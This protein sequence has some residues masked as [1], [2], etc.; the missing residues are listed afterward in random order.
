MT[1]CS[2]F[3]W[4]SWGISQTFNLWNVKVKS[5]SHVQL[6]VTPWTEEPTNFP[7]KSTGVGCHFL[8]QGIFPTQGS[9]PGLP[10]SRQTLYHLSHKGSPF[11]LWVDLNFLSFLSHLTSL[12]FYFRSGRF[13][14]FYLNS[15]T[16]TLL[17]EKGKHNF[18]ISLLFF[19]YSFCILYI[20]RVQYLLYF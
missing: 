12:L 3:S 1:S 13:P 10:H 20:S 14:Q 18:Q 4:S 19:K 9:N 2:L 8:L 11:N 6:F 15:S 5:L 17:N 7:G 16:F